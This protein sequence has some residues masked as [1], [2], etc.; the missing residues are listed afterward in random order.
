MF[1]L[2]IQYC[3]MT[4][5]LVQSSS[6]SQITAL[7]NKELSALE[8]GSVKRASDVTLKVTTDSGEILSETT[9]KGMENA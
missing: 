3:G 4:V 6:L 2:R 5:A 9:V 1:N 8:M 7:R